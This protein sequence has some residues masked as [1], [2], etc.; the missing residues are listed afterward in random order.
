MMTAIL[1]CTLA[2]VDPPLKL[3]KADTAGTRSYP[4]IHVPDGNSIVL[5]VGTHTARVRLL[6][7]EA[8]A[9]FAGREYHY[10]AIRFLKGL[11]RDQSV[12][13]RYED[14]APGNNPPLSLGKEPPIT[15]AYVYRA[16]DGL[17]VNLEAIRQGYGQ[18]STGVAFK[19]REPLRAE[20]RKA[21]VGGIGL[22][23][24]VVRERA[25]EG[26][27]KIAV[28]LPALV[29]G[30]TAMAGEWSETYR[31]QLRGEAKRRRLVRQ[32]RQEAAQWR[33]AVEWARRSA[34]VGNGPEKGDD[35]KE[36]K[37]DR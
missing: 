11:L 23:D 14:A 13:L 26:Y 12:Y 20:E 28:E 34:G 17:F 5:K 29:I 9:D 32:Q 2:A 1:V 7:V 21:R 6:G 16:S 8:P 27:A 4:V 36:F 33:R 31:A 30:R 35:D 19:L 25:S 22:W 24:P 18:A 3:E 15:L 10:A 37:D